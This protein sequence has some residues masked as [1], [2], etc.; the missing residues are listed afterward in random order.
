MRIL[1]TASRYWDDPRV[2][3]D[4][5][6][7]VIGG[8]KIFTV[9][10]GACPTGGD[11]QCDVICIDKG[12]DVERHPA[13][14]SKYGK[15]AGFIRNSDMVKLGADVCLAFI[16]NNSKGATMCAKLAE[17]AGIEVF[18]IRPLRRSCKS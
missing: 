9:V 7:Y 3:Y 8:R 14:W 18:R 13:E 17:D 11:Q 2:I 5:L 1:V 15:R 12:W 10:H 16:K 4:M 6:I